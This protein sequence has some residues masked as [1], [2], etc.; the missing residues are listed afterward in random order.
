VSGHSGLKTNELTLNILTLDAA[1]YPSLAFKVYIYIYIY[2]YPEC[3]FIIYINELLFVQYTDVFQNGLPVL[4]WH[5]I[6]EDD[7]EREALKVLSKQISTFSFFF[8][9]FFLDFSN[10]L[11]YE[12]FVFGSSASFF[13]FFFFALSN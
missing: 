6:V 13:F 12:L 3:I 2:A 10:P 11:T 7:I 4:K 8:F 9:F 5:E 1:L